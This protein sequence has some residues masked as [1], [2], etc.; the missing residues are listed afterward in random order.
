MKSKKKL[1]ISITVIGSILLIGIVCFAI[2]MS[3][4]ILYQNK[5]KS[6]IISDVDISGIADGVYI[7]EYDVDFIYVK[8]AVT[9]ESG[10]ITTID[11]IEHKQ[12]RG[13]AAESIIS[14]IV[15]QQRIDV[16]GITGATNSSTVIKKA[17]ENALS[18]S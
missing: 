8:V 17:I 2:Y 7:G 15:Q 13:K 16:D 12:D 5:V 10:K 4:V 18:E 3:S 9:V 1:K 6:T 11:I 14:D